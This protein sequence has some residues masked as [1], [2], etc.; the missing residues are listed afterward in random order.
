VVV[1]SY[2]TTAYHTC[3]YLW[4][5]DMEKARGQGLAEGTVAA[6]GPLGAVLG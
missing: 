6:P 4:A 5:R 1:G 3:L 2:T